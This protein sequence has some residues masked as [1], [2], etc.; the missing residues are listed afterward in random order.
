M[1]IK[2][3]IVRFEGSSYKIAP[4]GFPATTDILTTIT[5]IEAAYRMNLSV[6]Y[7]LVRVYVKIHFMPLRNHINTQQYLIRC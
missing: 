1:V 7:G 6:G 4:E 3:G 5:L 2:T